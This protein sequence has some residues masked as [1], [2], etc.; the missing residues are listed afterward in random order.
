MK[1]WMRRSF[2]PVE[3]ALESGVARFALPSEARVMRDKDWICLVR[4]GAHVAVCRGRL[5][6]DVLGTEGY[7]GGAVAGR[8]VGAASGRVAVLVGL[9]L[10]EGGRTRDGHAGERIELQVV[11]ALERVDLRREIE[12]SAGGAFATAIPITPDLRGQPSAG[13]SAPRRSGAGEHCRP[14]GGARSAG[15]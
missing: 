6:R 15:R 5:S 1:F 10:D 8:A 14:T 2:R 11:D 9:L 3:A 7:V 13:C 12:V 4:W